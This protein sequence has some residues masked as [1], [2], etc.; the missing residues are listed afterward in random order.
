MNMNVCFIG[1]LHFSCQF[2]RHVGTF[3]CLP[4]LNQYKVEDKV[5]CSR[6]Q[7]SVSSESPKSNTPPLRS[8]EHSYILL[9]Y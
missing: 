6:P 1:A 3:L 2:F 7:L 4:W 8:N 9:N 5:S